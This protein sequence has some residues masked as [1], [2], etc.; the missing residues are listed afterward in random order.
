MYSEAASRH[1]GNGGNGAAFIDI[2]C[3]AASI[4]SLPKRIRKDPVKL[5]VALLAAYPPD[6]TATQPFP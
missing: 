3:C 4:C 1:R 2:A 6:N 5:R